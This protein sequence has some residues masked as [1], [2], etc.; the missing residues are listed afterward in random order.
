MHFIQKLYY[1]R[2]ATNDVVKLIDNS[3]NTVVEY[4]QL[5][6]KHNL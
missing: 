3:G 6:I 4:L 5:N 2:N 1:L